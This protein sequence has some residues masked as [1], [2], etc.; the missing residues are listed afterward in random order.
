VIDVP[1][2]HAVQA[3]FV[4]PMRAVAVESDEEKLKPAKVR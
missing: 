4:L 1:E 3:Q 2:I